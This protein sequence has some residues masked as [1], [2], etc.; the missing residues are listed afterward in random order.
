MT[1]V[2]AITVTSPRTPV[3]KPLLIDRNKRAFQKM[4]SA[5]HPGNLI[6]GTMYI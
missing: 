6:S 3:T 1:E 2:S 4:A 5:G